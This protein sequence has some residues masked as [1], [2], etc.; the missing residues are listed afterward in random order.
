MYLLPTMSPLANLEAA[1]EVLN[2]IYDYKKNNWAIGQLYPSG[3]PDMFTYF[4]SMRWIP[5]ANYLRGTISLGDPSAYDKNIAAL[6]DYMHTMVY[7]E[8]ELI[9]DTIE[10]ILFYQQKNWAIGEQYPDA[11]PDCFVVF[12]A[13]RNLTIA[14]YLRGTVDIGY[15]SA[16]CENIQTLC[17]YRQQILAFLS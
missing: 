8:L 10:E 3:G 5:I 12:F 1:Q 15:P 2:Q 9:Q 11:G 13:Q 7:R 6:T 17:S 14:P 16:Y 4:F